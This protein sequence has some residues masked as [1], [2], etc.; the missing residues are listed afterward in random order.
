M[1]YS[2]MAY[3]YDALMQD[4]PYDQWENFAIKMIREYGSTVQHMADLGCGTGEITRRLSNKG[5]RMIGIDYSED[6]LAYAQQ[7]TAIA[8]P[9]QW[10]HQDIRELQGFHHNQ[11]DAVISFCDVINYLTTREEIQQVFQHVNHMLKEDGLF[12]FDIHSL[13]HIEENL[14]GQT[15]AEIYDDISY[16]WLCQPGE[17]S[18]EVYHDLTFF[19]LDDQQYERFD[20]THHQRTF[21]T[22]VYEDL[23]NQAGFDCLNL[24]Y[25]FNCNRENKPQKSE[26]VFFVCKKNRGS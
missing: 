6:M 1:S 16:V 22:Q 10:F 25:D 4:A 7:S 3:V 26:R 20:E 13:N 12:L 8:Q 15:F 17:N 14:K 23:L 19:V 5:F 2:K 11:L 18:G 9:I 21:A 24:C